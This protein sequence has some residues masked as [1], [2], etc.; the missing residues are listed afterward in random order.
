MNH[1]D[2]HHSFSYTIREP[3]G[4]TCG[5]GAWNYPLVNAVLKSAPA[6]IFGNAM[7]YKPS[8]M[9][10]S[11]ALMLAEIYEE[12]GLPRGVFQVLL[13]IVKL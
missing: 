11:S 6:L 5:I 2:S 13:G 8:E 1:L 4:L 3:L 7:V 9:T 12:A 10:P